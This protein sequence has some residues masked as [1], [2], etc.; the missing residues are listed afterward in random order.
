M[1]EG[2]YILAGG[3]VIRRK[4]SNNEVPVGPSQA[5][6]DGCI[7]NFHQFYISPEGRL[8]IAPCPLGEI[9]LKFIDAPMKEHLIPKVPYAVLQ[10]LYKIG[11]VCF[12]REELDVYYESED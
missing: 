5:K 11:D 9:K 4:S 2:S 10:S 8:E 1:L 3:L 12:Y 7:F 6:D